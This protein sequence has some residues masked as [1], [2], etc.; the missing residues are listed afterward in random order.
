VE[1]RGHAFLEIA[2]LADVKRLP[3]LAEHAVNTRQ[4]RQP[5]NE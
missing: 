1:V 4:I 3:A 2:R 5:G